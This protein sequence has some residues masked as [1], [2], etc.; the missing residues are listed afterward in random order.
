[1]NLKKFRDT[2]FASFSEKEI[3]R[4]VDV[5]YKEFVTRHLV[6]LDWDV[7]EVLE[8][9]TFRPKKSSLIKLIEK[10]FA[11]RRENKKNGRY[12]EKAEVTLKKYIRQYWMVRNGNERRKECGIKKTL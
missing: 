6:D 2:P 1:M 8:L 10:Y 12:T 11:V 9:C 3:Q 7:L 5:Y 4:M